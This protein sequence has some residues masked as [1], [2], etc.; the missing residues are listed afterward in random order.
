MHHFPIGGG[1]R[2]VVGDKAGELPGV[3]GPR[4]SRLFEVGP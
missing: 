4:S 2:V 3:G 1:G